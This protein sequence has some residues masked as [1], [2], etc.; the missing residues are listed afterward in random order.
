MDRLLL[1][2]LSSVLTVLVVDAGL[3]LRDGVAETPAVLSHP[4]HPELP[5]CAPAIL[6]LCDSFAWGCGIGDHRETL[7]GRLH[8][9]TGVPVAN[10]GISGSQTGAWVE[11]AR[12]VSH[13]RSW[14]AVVVSWSPRDGVAW[15]DRQRFDAGLLDRYR[16][17]V[18]SRRY[19]AWLNEGYRPGV[20]EWE[21]AQVN[22]RCIRDAFDAPVL[23]AVW[24]VMVGLRGRYPVPEVHEAMGAWAEREG[25]PCVDMLPAFRGR[26]DASL[27]VSATDDHPNAE[28]TAIAARAIMPT[29][30]EVM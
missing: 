27:W 5:A 7:S 6:L 3:R 9:L 18:V 12:Q 29:L 2:L 26:R 15:R 30:M 28:A 20:P 25:W 8:A 23:L 11:R 4:T 10:H 16:K 13:E 19:E 1:A 24:P 17:L 22:L 21:A 14:A